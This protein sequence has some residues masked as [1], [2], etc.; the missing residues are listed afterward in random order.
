MST[1]RRCKAAL[2]F[3]GR[4]QKTAKTECGKRVNCSQ[5]A[6]D[7]ET[8]CPECRAA[9]GRTIEALQSIA[10]YHEESFGASDMTRDAKATASDP[11][12]YHTIYFL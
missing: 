7:C 6:V 10:K 9:V 11:R 2:S 5:I 4:S 8:D 1:K 12:L 3:I